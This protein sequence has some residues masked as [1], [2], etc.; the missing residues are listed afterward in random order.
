MKNKI[1][2][3]IIFSLIIADFILPKK[4]ASM[5]DLHKPF[6]VRSDNHSLYVSDDY[7]VKVYS[8]K[9]YKFQRKIGRKGNG[10]GE[11]IISPSIQILPSGKIFLVDSRKYVIVESNGNMVKEKKFHTPFM[12]LKSVG[13]NFV[14]R[15]YTFQGNHFFNEISIFDHNFKQVKNLRK[16]EKTSPTD[17]DKIISNFKIVNHILAVECYKDKIF[18][19]NGEKGFYYEVYDRNGNLLSI[20]NKTYEKLQISEKDK[21][22]WID[23]FKNRNMKKHW[24]RFKK[25]VKNLYDLFPKY[26]PAMQDFIV[27]DGNVYV[28]TYKRRNSME[29]YVILDLKGNI[30]KR[31]F[32]PM[33]Y[34]NLFTFK[35]NRFYYLVEN[36][37]EEIWELHSVEM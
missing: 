23:R 33:A 24:T 29:E 27:S 28:K 34:P 13:D 1:T 7:S 5:P 3:S 17:L 18:Y 8:L 15:K 25:H 22:F 6:M 37:D 9:T 12:N 11:Y 26:Y 16:I 21:S 20:I 19:A 30:R 31:T 35:D 2:L 4:I 10:P 32:L 14:G 36:D